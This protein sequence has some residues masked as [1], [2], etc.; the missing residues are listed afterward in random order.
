MTPKE[1]ERPNAHTDYLR[2]RSIYYS[3]DMFTDNGKLSLLSPYASPTA[4]DLPATPQL[5]EGFPPTLIHYVRATSF[6]LKS[7]IDELTGYRRDP[8]SR[9]ARTGAPDE[10]G[11]RERG[12]GR[13]R[14]RSAR[15]VHIELVRHA[16]G[17]DGSLEEIVRG[18]VSQSNT[19]LF[20]HGM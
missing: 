4:A 6:P 7:E 3:L 18:G 1:G 5:F 8:D 16:R 19:S 12:R 15:P 14:G 20:E 10:A 9:L 17:T 11:G 2:T 13:R